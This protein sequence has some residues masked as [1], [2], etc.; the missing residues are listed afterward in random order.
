VRKNAT[1]TLGTLSLVVLAACAAPADDAASS[2]AEI[3]HGARLTLRCAEGSVTTNVVMSRREGSFDLVATSERGVLFEVPHQRPSINARLED[4]AS[5]EVHEYVDF[6]DEGHVAVPVDGPRAI[7][8]DLDGEESLV[9]RDAE[10]SLT[11]A[12]DVKRGKL[13]R[14]LGIEPIDIDDVD[15]KGVRAVAFDV[16]DTLAYTTPTFVRAF[17]TGAQ[18]KP[19]DVLFWSHANACDVGCAES[20]LAL[21]DGSTRALPAAAPSVAKSAALALIRQHRARGHKVYAIT[22]RPDIGGDGLRSYLE[23]A[24][25]FQRSEIFFE[26]DIDAPGNPKGK[27]DRIESLDLDIFYGDSDS[28]ITDAAAAFVDASGARRKEVRAVRFLRSPRS[29]NRKAGKLAK[30]NPGYFGERILADSYD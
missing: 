25:G 8:I 4:G 24:F 10:R 1:N 26:P 13:L 19:D 18:P 12:C 29:S 22:A 3:A 2:D 15:M 17:A 7:E 21:P 28:D 14:F 27:T 20:V 11:L 30:Y 9:F 23:S 16:D 6:H 5:R